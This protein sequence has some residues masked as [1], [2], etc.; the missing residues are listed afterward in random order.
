MHRKLV[1][2]RLA[3]RSATPFC[4]R[5]CQQRGRRTFPGTTSDAY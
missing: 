2:A 1:F 3:A 4:L 5:D